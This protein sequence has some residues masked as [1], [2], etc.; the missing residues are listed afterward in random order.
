MSN[1]EIVVVLSSVK[2]C[3]T[4]FILCSVLIFCDVITGYLKAWKQREINSSI[5]R[6]GYI[7]KVGWIVALLLGV[8]LDQFIH[9]HIF[10]FGTAIVCIATEAISVYENLSAVG[11]NLP[12]AKYFE[13]VKD[14]YE[15]EHE[16]LSEEESSK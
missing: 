7:K 15:E 9:V 6:D 10:L 14:K 16:E 2:D 12:F 1:E 8:V 13:K 3:R 4:L 5:S 11:V